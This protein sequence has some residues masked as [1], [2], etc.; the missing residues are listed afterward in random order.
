MITTVAENTAMTLPVANGGGAMAVYGRINDPMEFING[1]GKVFMMA[2]ACGVKTESEGKVLAL[3]CMCKGKDPFELQ[4]DYHIIDGKLSMRADTMLA[5]FRE[6]GGKHVWVKDGTDG[7]AAELKLTDKDG[8][9][10]VS[11]FDINKA[12]DAGYVKAGSQWIKR[13]DQMLRSRCITDGVRMIA[14][15]VNSG[16]YTPEELDDSRVID[17]T[18]T[19]VRTAEEVEARRKEL[20]AQAAASNPPAM[21]TAEQLAARQQELRAAAAAKI[22]VTQT[23]EPVAKAAPVDKVIEVDAV[24]FDVPTDDAT[25]TQSTTPAATMSQDDLRKAEQRTLKLVEIDGIATMFGQSAAAIVAAMNKRDGT[26][27]ATLEDLPED[28][29]DLLLSRLRQKLADRNATA[30]ERQPG[31]EG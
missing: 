21:R 1:M 22:T 24:P 3:A 9:V 28:K 16:R 2:G 23:A 7:I 12:K 31:E 18:A 11:K 17:S 25:V 19:P 20:Q 14:P 30:H 26:N 15:E 27:H 13:P 4:E 8:N 10:V 29:A 5:K 6:R